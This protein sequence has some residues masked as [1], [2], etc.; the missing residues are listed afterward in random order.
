MVRRDSGGQVVGAA[1]VE[2]DDSEEGARVVLGAGC[3]GG[4][5]NDP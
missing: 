3:S 2:D 5:D 4:V 1:V